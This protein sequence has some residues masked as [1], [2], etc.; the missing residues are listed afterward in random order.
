[1]YSDLVLNPGNSN[2]TIIVIYDMN[3][4]LNVVPMYKRLKNDTDKTE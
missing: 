1:M 4:L 3:K 2:I